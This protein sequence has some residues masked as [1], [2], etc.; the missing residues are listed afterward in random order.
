[1]GLK[2][3]HSLDFSFKMWKVYIKIPVSD[4]RE[5]DKTWKLRLHG[6]LSFEL[7]SECLLQ[8]EHVNYSVPQTP[9]LLVVFQ[10]QPASVTHHASLVSE[11]TQ[12]G[13]DFE[14]RFKVILAHG[15][16]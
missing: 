3:A 10:T 13:T 12:D 11:D 16:N 4:S 2:V 5:K 8:V 1:M 15:T 7:S 9:L 6:N 14:F